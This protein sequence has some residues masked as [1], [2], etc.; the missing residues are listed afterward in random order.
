[1]RLP[2]VQHGRLL[3]ERSGA[4]SAG[5]VLSGVDPQGGD[6]VCGWGLIKLKIPG[7]ISLV[8][9]ESRVSS[10]VHAGDA[11]LRAPCRRAQPA[12]QPA[13]STGRSASEYSWQADC[14]ERDQ[15]SQS[16]MPRRPPRRSW[17]RRRRRPPA[18]APARLRWSKG[19]HRVHAP[20]RLGFTDH[21]RRGAGVRPPGH[22]A[23]QGEAHQEALAAAAAT[24]SAPRSDATQRIF[25][26][27]RE[28]AGIAASGGRRVLQARDHRDAGSSR[29][30][31]EP[32]Q[33]P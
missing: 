4:A 6:K 8:E 26:G 11:T 22:Q 24:A 21:R 5:I 23:G 9:R 32:A 28:H 3:R 25:Q 14:G 16:L 2:V 13:A 7:G 15:A 33:P 20:Q 30:V 10:A 12:A 31:V 19:A 29:P 1:M 18:A 17:R 27:R